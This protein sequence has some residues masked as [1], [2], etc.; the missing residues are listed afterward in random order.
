VGVR[1][2]QRPFVQGRKIRDKQNWP[3]QVKRS[4]I[5][6]ALPKKIAFSNFFFVA[7]LLCT[8]ENIRH[9]LPTRSTRRT[10]QYTISML[11]VA[12][13]ITKLMGPIRKTDMAPNPFAN[14]GDNI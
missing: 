5:E 1:K 14:G 6:D 7:E 11:I 12:P 9:L 10:S 3:R 2:V 4:K 13:K 8:D